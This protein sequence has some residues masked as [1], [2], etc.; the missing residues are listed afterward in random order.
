MPTPNED[1]EAAIKQR[2]EAVRVAKGLT[3]KAVYSAIGISRN[4][5]EVK[6]AGGSFYV[7]ELIR[8]AGALGMD[9]DELVRG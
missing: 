5:Y 4:T 7:R 1:R 8:A 9:F 3:R 2:I 6:M